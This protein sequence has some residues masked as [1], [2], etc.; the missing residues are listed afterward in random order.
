MFLPN[1]RQKKREF[2]FEI[3]TIVCVHYI[4]QNKKIK[5]LFDPFTLNSGQF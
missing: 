3:H 5:I 1:A 4:E 2:F